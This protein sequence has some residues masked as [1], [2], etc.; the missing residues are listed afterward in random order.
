MPASQEPA[1][2]LW[3]GRRREGGERKGKSTKHKEETLPVFKRLQ[4]PPAALQ[5]LL[6]DPC[7]TDDD[8]PGGTGVGVR[9][10][11][12]LC[13]RCCRC[14]CLCVCLFSF[15]FDSNSALE[16]KGGPGGP[17][18]QSRNQIAEPEGIRISYSR[19]SKMTKNTHTLQRTNSVTQSRTSPTAPLLIDPVRHERPCVRSTLEHSLRYRTAPG[20]SSDMS[21]LNPWTFGFSCLSFAY[22][23]DSE[24]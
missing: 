13:L 17:K 4:S 15:S 16:F 18:D 6:D 8:D 5:S 12:F 21:I 2:K 1:G 7:G 19:V 11:C 9:W 14:C 10:W 23:P 20:F 24:S 22:F 3:Y